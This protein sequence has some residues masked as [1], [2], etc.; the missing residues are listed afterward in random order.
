MAIS[1]TRFV[2]NG[3]LVVVSAGM[4]VGGAPRDVQLLQLAVDLH[5]QHRHSHK[6]QLFTVPF[7]SSK[8]EILTIQS[9]KYSTLCTRYSV[10]P[11]A[12]HVTEG[13][14]PWLSGKW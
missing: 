6:T 13:A 7:A 10:Q 1:E 3:R 5:L 11:L 4:G 14:V 2:N 12:R 9:Q 8:L